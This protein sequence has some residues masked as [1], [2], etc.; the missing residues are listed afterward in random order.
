MLQVQTVKI[1]GNCLWKVAE[2]HTHF[3]MAVFTLELSSSFRTQARCHQDSILDFHDDFQDVGG[4]C[5]RAYYVG[6]ITKKVQLL[7]L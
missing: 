1:F 5:E 4:V 2:G 3:A 7:T 6:P